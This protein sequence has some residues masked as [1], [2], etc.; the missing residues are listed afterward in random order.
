MCLKNSS[1][2]HVDVFPSITCFSTCNPNLDG[3]GSFQKVCDFTRSVEELHCY[4]KFWSLALWD[5]VS[6]LVKIS[7]PQGK[8]PFLN[9]KS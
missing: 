7:I 4:R 8:K 9:S 3:G 1:K 2:F 6:T 5:A